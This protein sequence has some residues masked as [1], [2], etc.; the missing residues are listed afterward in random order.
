MNKK[1][2]IIESVTRTLVESISR[3]SFGESSVHLKVH[4]GR[5]VSITYSM[6]ES[7]RTEIPTKEAQT[8]AKN[9]N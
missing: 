7:I 6:T 9:D 1:D 5:I 4:A 3:I 8:E 2:A